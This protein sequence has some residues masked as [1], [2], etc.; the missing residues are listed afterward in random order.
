[1]II[2]AMIKKRGYYEREITKIM[3]GMQK[4]KQI[5]L[6]ALL[7]KDSQNKFL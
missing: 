1:M 6:S 5:T 4:E 7:S 3:H 2:V